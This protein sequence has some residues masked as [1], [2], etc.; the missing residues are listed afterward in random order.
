[1]YSQM[2]PLKQSQQLP[3]CALTGRTIPGLDKCAAVLT[4][5]IARVIVEEIDLML[6]AGKDLR[7]QNSGG[8]H[9]QSDMTIL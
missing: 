4:L 1:M 8:L 2:C 7:Q 5:E 9:T 6:E 3:A